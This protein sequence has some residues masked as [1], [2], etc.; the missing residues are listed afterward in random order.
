MGIKLIAFDLD[1]TFLDP[2]KNIPPDNIRALEEAAAKGVVIVPATGRIVGGVPQQIRELPFIRYYVTANGAFVY[3]ALEDKAVARAEIPLEEA[4][5]LL[6]Y[7]DGLGIP[8]DCY[9][10]GWGYMSAGMQA[11]ARDFV[12]D[13][14]IL[15]LVL[16]LRR[17]VPEL[18]EFLRQK[19]GSVQKL[20]F[21]FTDM[22][23]RARQLEELPG[24]FPG[25]A[26]TTSVPFNIEVNSSAA[27]KGQGLAA[28]CRR[29]DIRPEEVLAFGDDR[30]DADMIRFA[31]IGV[32]M[33]NAI[34]ELRAAAD[35]VAGSNAEAGVA[36]GIE[37]FVLGE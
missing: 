11:R 21:Y 14:G 16:T 9:Q 20:Q 28:L 29:L 37:R 31:G 15:E 22:Q 8:Y 17:S 27:T 32:A 4:L 33:E 18:K 6:R 5:S 25:M 12:H 1:G 2:K 3:D 7:E 23:E 34:E 35:W 19:G 36:R 24:M 26:F 30:N 10:D 13:P